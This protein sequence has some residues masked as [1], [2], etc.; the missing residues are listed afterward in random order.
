MKQSSTGVSVERYWPG[1]G[2]KK[3]PLQIISE[4]VFRGETNEVRSKAFI[5]TTNP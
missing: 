1:W 3:F 5:E 2:G 4:N